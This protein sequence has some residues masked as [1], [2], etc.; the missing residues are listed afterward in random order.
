MLDAEDFE[1][2]FVESQ[3]A[4]HETVAAERFHRV[5]AHAAHHFLDLVRPG[6]HE[7]DEPPR[8]LLGIQPLDEFG[9]LGRNAPITLARMT[10]AAQVTPE[11]EQRRRRNRN[12]VRAQR[13][14][15][16][17]VRARTN[18]SAH[19][20][21]N[22]AA[23]PFLAQALVHARKG[24]FHGNA[25]VV[26]DPRRRR[27]R[28][29]AESV[30]RND[31]RAAPRN[32]AR[33]RRNV[34]HRRDF[35]DDG[36]L[37]PRRLFERI[38]EL[39][40]ILDG[41][42]VVVR[43]GADRVRALGDHAGLGNFAHDLRPGQVS[44]DSGLRALSHLDLDRRARG[45]IILMYAEP[46]RRDLHHGVRAV[47]VKVLVQSALARVVQGSEFLGGFRE[48]GMRV[49]TDRAV[50][51]RRK[52]NGR[53]E[54]DHGLALGQ[55]FARGVPPDPLGLAAQ[56]DFGF[57]GFPQGVDGRI[58]NLGSVDDDFVPIDGERLGIAHGREQH[59]AALRLAVDLGHGAG[60]PVGIVPERVVRLAD[61]ERAGGTERDATLTVHALGFV[62][63]QSARLF[64]KAVH[65]VC[66]LFLAH[67]ATD[68]TV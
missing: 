26:P 36:L 5:D 30:D 55:D 15:L 10:T 57:H 45:Q 51:H 21:R 33:D 16:D 48:R 34:V 8:P 28:A 23:D 52:Q 17:H 43:R 11:R 61:L 13:D 38:D 60:V 6:V 9:T 53:F 12:R 56:K 67:A 39:A 22:F 47:L 27:A 25:H 63:N 20:Q 64:V 58:G 29:P 59:A 42:N 3:A 7:V 41:I 54:C 18:A 49:V 32:A 40:Q 37:I 46:P 66:A 24:E 50:T 4:Q 62:G 35:D 44:A 31:V 19:H 68:A 14:R 65:L 2:F 1:F